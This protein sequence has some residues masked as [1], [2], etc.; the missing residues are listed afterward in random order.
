MK[1]VKISLL[2]MMFAMLP[3]SGLTQDASN[4]ETDRFEAISKSME[5][6]FEASYVTALGGIDQTGN[7]NQ[8]DLFY[9]GQIYMHLNLLNGD[10]FHRWFKDDSANSSSFFNQHI[11]SVYF[12]IRIQMRQLQSNSSPVRTPSYNPGIRLFYTNSAWLNSENREAMRYLSLG[13]HHY[14]NGQSGLHTDPVTGAINTIDGSFSTDYVEFAY[15]HVTDLSLLKWAKLNVRQYLTGLTWE[16]GQND[17]Y[18]TNVV[19][20]TGKTKKQRIRLPALGRYD[21]SATAHLGYKF[22][23]NFI[24]ANVRAKTKDNVQFGIEGEFVPVGW[25]DLGLYA[26]W[27]YGYDYYNINYRNKI[28]RLQFGVVQVFGKGKSEK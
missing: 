9:E 24:S 12:P 23:R 19:T 27:D 1:A 14:S 4:K 13:F 2:L 6:Y 8:N 3:V 15:Y 20:V 21:I 10:S 11:F 7:I 22:G 28:N 17:Y 25:S 26:R 5:Q 18:Q 16:Q